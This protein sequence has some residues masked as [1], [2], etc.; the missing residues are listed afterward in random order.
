MHAV[1]YAWTNNNIHCMNK[2]AFWRFAGILGRPGDR[3]D[4]EEEERGLLEEDNDSSEGIHT[5]TFE[6]HSVL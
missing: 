3:S 5:L 2:M 6:P 4:D 1:F